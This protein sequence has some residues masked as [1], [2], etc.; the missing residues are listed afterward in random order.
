MK[1]FPLRIASVTCLLSPYTP[2]VK[3]DQWM[4]ALDSNHVMPEV[5]EG[6][7]IFEYFVNLSTFEWEK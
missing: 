6:E 1:I 4:R 5:E 7:T 3:L 2:R